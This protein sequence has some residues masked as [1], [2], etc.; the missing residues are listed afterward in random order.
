MVDEEPKRIKR[1]ID[2][3]T[4][5]EV[6]RILR[7]CGG[8]GPI[9]RRNRAMTVIM[10]RAGLRISEVLALK[11]KDV[12]VHRG[13]I[14]VHRGKGNKSRTVG[15]DPEACDV[16]AVWV[17]SRA[18]VHGI[19]AS[20]PLICGVKLKSGK[21]G[22]A[23][24]KNYP[25]KFYAALAKKIGLN[26]RVTPHAFRH[27]FACELVRE[28]IDIKRI[29]QLLG[30]ASLHATSYYLQ[31]LMPYEAIQAILARPAWMSVEAKG[32]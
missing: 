11:P 29:Q 30:H 20:S 7:A 12:D 6:R 14:R 18:L 8:K 27:T 26:K 15:I 25:R 22:E 2:I 4:A 17:A 21:N 5:D 32:K 24:P 9:A 3:F 13:T 1:D 16:I 10:W 28:G 31:N 19:T 23:L